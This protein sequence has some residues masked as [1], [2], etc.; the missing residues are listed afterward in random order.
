LHRS[1]TL[2]ALG[3]ESDAAREQERAETLI[4]DAPVHRGPVLLAH[5][6]EPPPQRAAEE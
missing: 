2:R 1:A 4:G 3:R 5:L 6:P